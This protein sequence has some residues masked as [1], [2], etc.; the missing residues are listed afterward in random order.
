[1]TSPV[2]VITGVGPGNGVA[3][4]RRMSA[5]GYR[6]AMFARSA[7]RLRAL[8][9]EIDGSKG[10][11][12]DVGDPGAVGEA[13]S[14]VRAELGPVEV[15]LHNAGSGV[16]G[17][18]ETITTSSFEAAWRVNAFGALITARQVIPAMKRRGRGAIVGSMTR[19]VRR[20]CVRHSSRSRR[21]RRT[22][23]ARRWRRR[24]GTATRRS[25]ASG[26]S[27]GSSRT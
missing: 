14:R 25:A 10:Y 5:E 12:V 22:G 8:E 15:L 11:S 20:W 26:V 9:K 18:V 21:A 2:C 13:F 3:F 17:D 27:T 7:E 23:A 24:R 16:W 19:S 1:M 4:S 6:V